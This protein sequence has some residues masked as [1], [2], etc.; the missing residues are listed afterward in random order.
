MYL[1]AT[2]LFR[3]KWTNR[4]HE[5]WMTSLLKKRPDLKQEDLERT[6]ELMN[7][8]ALD[9]L[10]EDFEDLIPTISLP[11]PDDRHVLA[12]AIRGGADRIVTFNLQDFPAAALQKHGIEAQPPDSFITGLID[13]DFELVCTAAKRHRNSLRK[14]PKTVAEYLETLQC[15]RL[16]QTVSRLQKYRSSL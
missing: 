2:D 7:R 16:P 15:Q 1:A 5:E 9:C 8:H 14:P 6:C 13:L 12:A 10:V 11:D 3:A 4:I